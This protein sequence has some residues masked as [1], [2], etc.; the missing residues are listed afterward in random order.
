MTGPKSWKPLV[1]CELYFLLLSLLFFG[2][3]VSF[4]GL[5]VYG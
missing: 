4:K 5:I 2:A 1:K 3:D